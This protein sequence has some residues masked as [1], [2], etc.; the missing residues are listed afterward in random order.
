[1]MSVC[2]PVAQ[3]VYS[4]NWLNQTSALSE[5][6]LSVSAQGIYRITTCFGGPASGVDSDWGLW[7]TGTNAYT[8]TAIGSPDT[9]NGGNQLNAVNQTLTQTYTL[10]ASSTIGFGTALESGTAVPY[11]LFIVIEQLA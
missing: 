11:D 10:A 4:N 3:V 9:A 6:L 5:T 2:I 1:M 7:L 8:G